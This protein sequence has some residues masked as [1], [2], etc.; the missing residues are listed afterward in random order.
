MSKTS[1]DTL[2]NKTLTNPTISTIL[3]TGTLTLPTST[4][5]LI[6]RTTTDTLSNKTLTNPIISTILNT[7]TLTLPTS[8]DT[9]IGRATTDSLTN[10]TL[11]ATNIV[12]DGAL[13]SNIPKLNAS[14][15]FSGT[16]NT[17]QN[18]LTLQSNTNL[19]TTYTAPTAG[20]LGFIKFGTASTPS[21]NPF[22]LVVLQVFN[23]ASILLPPGVWNVFGQGGFYI[24]TGGTIRKQYI[25]ISS[26]NSLISTQCMTST[27]GMTTTTSDL[28]IQRINEI[29]VSNGSIFPN[30][31]LNINVDFSSGVYQITTYSQ[32]FTQFYAVRIA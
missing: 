12:N 13:S 24:N 10:K 21:P 7:G 16:T 19:P 26:S 14:N 28:Y 6:G 27:T 8:T 18:S 9:L 11:D 3:N 5:T 2:T 15:T 4:D 30:V 25:S 31:F 17:F 32:G 20:Q 1:T 22:T 29:V 23:L